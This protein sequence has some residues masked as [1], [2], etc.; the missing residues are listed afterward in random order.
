MGRRND[1]ARNDH[2]PYPDLASGYYNRA[3]AHATSKAF[4]RAWADLHMYR[5]MGR[6]P[7]PS[8]VEELTR[9]SGQSE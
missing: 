3:L 8:F 6:V 9:D 2:E 5:E 4:D 1:G 7:H